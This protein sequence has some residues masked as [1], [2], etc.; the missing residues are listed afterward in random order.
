MACE[1][2]VNDF[3]FLDGVVGPETE[4]TLPDDHYLHEPSDVV[5][6][7]VITFQKRVGAKFFQ[8]TKNLIPLPEL[9]LRKRFS[10]VGFHK[11]RIRD[12][13]RFLWPRDFSKTSSRTQ[14]LGLRSSIRRVIS[15]RQAGSC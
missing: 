13:F 12:H 9:H 6:L 3:D 5:A 2:K 4:G 15:V 14:F 11:N 10:D 7:N 8:Q 1:S